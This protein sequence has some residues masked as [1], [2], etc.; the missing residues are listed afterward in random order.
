MTITFK[1]YR[2]KDGSFMLYVNR[3]NGVS[4]GM[5]PERQFTTYGK[6]VTDGQRNAVEAALKAF[7]AVSRPFTGDLSKH[8]EPKADCGL[9]V[10]AGTDVANIGGMDVGADGAYV[11]RNGRIAPCGVAFEEE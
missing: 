8:S 3:S 5:S 7:E 1:S 9:F 2:R 10:L 11:I 6:G 4:V